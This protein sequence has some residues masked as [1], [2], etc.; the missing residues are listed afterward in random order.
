MFIQMRRVT[1]RS[2]RRSL[3]R[4]VAVLAFGAAAWLAAPQPAFA[5]GVHIPGMQSELIAILIPVLVFII[6]TGL[7]ILGVFL[8]YRRD[9]GSGEEDG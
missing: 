8:Y 4:S 3:F 9:F 5:H 1:V 6:V 7:G 2:R